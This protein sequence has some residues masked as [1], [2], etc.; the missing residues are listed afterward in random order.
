MA[1]VGVRSHAHSMRCRRQVYDEGMTR[2]RQVGHRGWSPNWSSD[3]L[4]EPRVNGG[5]VVYASEDCSVLR[6]TS[7]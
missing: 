1:R 3:V 7:G 2:Q 5:M 4:H 6:M